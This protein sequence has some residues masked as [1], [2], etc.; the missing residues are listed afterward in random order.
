MQFYMKV[1]AGRA[2]MSSGTG[3]D[4]AVESP[5]PSEQEPEGKPSDKGLRIRDA[6][7]EDAPVIARI[8]VQAF[9]G[10]YRSTFGNLG[11]KR[12]TTLL[13]QL[14]LAGNLSLETTYVAEREGQVVGLAI[15]HIGKSIGRGSAWAYGRRLLRHLGLF[16][17][18]RAFVGGLG[19]NA[20]LDRRIPRAPDL[21]YIEA[22]AVAEEE[23]GK[24]IGTLLIE[25]AMEW[26]QAQRRTR[27]ALHV[28]NSNTGA[29]RLYQ[30]MGFQ[31]WDLTPTR[32]FWGSLFAR[33]APRWSAMLMVRSV[34]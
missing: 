5:L 6:T 10:L 31:P 29:Q 14:Y 34:P 22:L 2:K 21:A 12:L 28:L 27:I 20:M 11:A 7:E 23:R 8:L 1:Y 19:A 32:R 25:S 24:G 33:R 4:D 16:R 9:P 17:A 3:E 13:T 30:R 18:W 15:L 26:T